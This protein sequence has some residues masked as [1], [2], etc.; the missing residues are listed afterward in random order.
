MLYR[1]SRKYI[2]FHPYGL[3]HVIS[4]LSGLERPYRKT[5]S[6]KQKRIVELKF[7]LIFFTLSYL[8]NVSFIIVM[9]FHVHFHAGFWCKQFP[10]NRALMVARNYFWMRL[11]MFNSKR[12]GY[13]SFIT[14]TALV[15]FQSEMSIFMIN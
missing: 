8:A 4:N 15:W 10:T 12:L 6:M 7:Y 1:K 3:F 14:L 13:K 5:D 9:N 2:S 11:Y